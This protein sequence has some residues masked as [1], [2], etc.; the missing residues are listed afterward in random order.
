MAATAPAAGGVGTARRQ[1]ACS[2]DGRHARGNRHRPARHSGRCRQLAQGLAGRGVQG[3]GHGQAG[4]VQA[5]TD[6]MREAGYQVMLS[7]SGYDNVDDEALFRALLGRRPDAMLI[8]G[9]GA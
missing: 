8:T 9:A 4:L 3:I 1:R 2:I 7:L 6:T 5:F